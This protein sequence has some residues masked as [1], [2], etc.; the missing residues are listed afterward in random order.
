MDIFTVLAVVV[1]AV[2]ATSAYLLFNGV[3]TFD[4]NADTRRQTRRPY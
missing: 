3:P 4:W 1:A 2:T